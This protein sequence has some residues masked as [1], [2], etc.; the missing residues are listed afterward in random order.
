MALVFYNA[1]DENQSTL[2]DWHKAKR[3][4]KENHKALSGMEDEIKERLDSLRHRCQV[5]TDDEELLAE[6]GEDSLTEEDEAWKPYALAGVWIIM[7]MAL[8]FLVLG[9]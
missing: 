7:G 5:I 9:V 8:K 4:V 6:D 3:S 1:P 2:E